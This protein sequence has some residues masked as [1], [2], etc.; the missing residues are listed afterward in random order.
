MTRGYRNN[1]PLN[2]RRSVQEFQGEITSNDL[3]F[4]TFRS[5]AYGYR[6]AMKIL[7]TYIT[8]Y[9]CDTIK[10]IISRWAPA[11][12]NNTQGYIKTVSSRTKIP[13]S[14]KITFTKGFICAIVSAMSY[15]ENGVK[16]DEK[17]VEKGWELL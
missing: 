8:K 13:I 14:Q 11:N 3:S 7:K 1:N 15:V 9:K 4:K 16:A 2:I 17:D 5:M 6:A 12:E 10:S